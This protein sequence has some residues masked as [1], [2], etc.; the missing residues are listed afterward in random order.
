MT[1]PIIR[2]LFQNIVCFSQD[3]VQNDH[4]AR[5]RI[6]VQIYDQHIVNVFGRLFLSRDPPHIQ[7]DA[8]GG[9]LHLVLC[10][11]VGTKGIFMGAIYLLIWMNP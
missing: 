4:L 10:D 11:Y 8:W 2:L 5:V 3:V 9:S 7:L 6:I 1:N